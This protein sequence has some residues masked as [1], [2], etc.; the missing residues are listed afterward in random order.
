MRNRSSYVCKILIGIFNVEIHAAQD[1]AVILIILQRLLRRRVR[2]DNLERDDHVAVF[3]QKRNVGPAGTKVMLRI[4]GNGH[5]KQVPFIVSAACATFPF[6]RERLLLFNEGAEQSRRLLLE[7]RMKDGLAG[8]RMLT[9]ADVR[10]VGT[11]GTLAGLSAATKHQASTTVRTDI[12]P[13]TLGTFYSD[14]I[15]IMVI[16]KRYERVILHQI[17]DMFCLSSLSASSMFV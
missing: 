13:A 6:N 15:T 10:E 4:N 3:I 17:S 8:T 16:S 2:Y 5:I 9:I 1:D 7:R 12:L 11:P 14:D